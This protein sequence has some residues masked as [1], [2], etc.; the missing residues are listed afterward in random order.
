MLAEG[1][2]RAFLAMGVRHVV[3]V[4]SEQKIADVAASL[5]TE[6]FY[7]DLFAGR[8]VSD[9]FRLAYDHTLSV[10][11]IAEKYD[12]GMPILLLQQPGHEKDHLFPLLTADGQL[13]DANRVFMSVP[14]HNLPADHEYV[15]ERPTTTFDALKVMVPPVV[16][17]VGLQRYHN[18]VGPAGVGKSVLARMVCEQKDVF[19]WLTINRTCLPARRI[20]QLT[21]ETRQS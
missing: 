6:K 16:S 20:A 4:Q 3:A 13:R 17:T 1:L 12:K 19:F 21:T 11:R 8:S 5:F 18:F 7:C 9:A 2:A 14:D 15:L 10:P